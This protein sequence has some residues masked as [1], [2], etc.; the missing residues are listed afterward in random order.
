[1]ISLIVAYNCNNLIADENGKIP[2]SIKEDLKFFRQQT[3]E[4]T[5]IMGRKTWQSLPE[6]YR[7]LPNRNNIIITRDTTVF[8]RDNFNLFMQENANCYAV[9]NIDVA[10][11]IA[12]ILQKEIFVVGG[13][14]IYKYFLEYL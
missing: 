6:S 8:C 11:Q 1:M 9:A 7:P 13:G 3:W 14:E 4:K 2:W 12:K 10:L 5:C